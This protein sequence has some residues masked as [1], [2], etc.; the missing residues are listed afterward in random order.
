[1]RLG[2]D[3][4]RR[5]FLFAAA[6]VLG[7][8]PP[9]GAAHAQAPD[10]SAPGALFDR[11]CAV[12]HDNSATRAPARPSLRAMSPNLI[13]DSLSHGMM[14]AQG[15]VLTAE[16]RVA[17]AEYLTGRKVGDEAPMAG[18]VRRP[19]AA[20]FARRAAVQRLG[21][22]CRKLAVPAEPGAQRRRSS[23]ARTQMGLRRSG[24]DR[25]V[26]PADRRSGPRFHRR[27]ERPRLRA[28]HAHRLHLL[29]LSRA[30]RREDRHH[31]RARR[32][33]DRR[34]VRRPPWTCLLR[35]RRDRGNDLEGRRRRRTG[36]GDHGRPGP[37]RE[38]AL[39]SNRERR[40]R[41][42]RPA[43]LQRQRGGR[44]ARRGDRRRRLDD[45]HDP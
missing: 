38:Q 19:L 7:L 15:S 34:A 9:S 6:A 35:R 24:R 10:E 40:R 16:Q 25:D 4:R 27:A 8:A 11:D 20:A 12:C 33:P 37:V 2:E 29:G 13:V 43:M 36:S 30:R 1:M 22:E 17:L 18:Q 3:L 42:S 5:L 32:R 41:Q 14:K 23:P 39:Y 31:G 44:C 45:L 26:R 21:R 28:R